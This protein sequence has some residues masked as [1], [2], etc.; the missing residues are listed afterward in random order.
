MQDVDGLPLVENELDVLARLVDLTDLRVLEV[1][2]GAARLARDLLEAHPG[3]TV[4]GIETDTV[5]LAKNQARPQSGLHFLQAS[6]TALPFANA[7]FDLVLM[8][9]S[10]HHIPMD[11]MDQ[12]LAEAARVL[13][14]GG[15][16][17]VSE[18]VYAGAFNAIV[19]LFNDEGVV[20]AAA[21]RALDRMLVDT[22]H[23]QAEDTVGFATAVT[24]TDFDTFERRMMRPTFADRHVDEALR[25]RVR[26]A[27]APHW[28]AGGA[29]FRRPMQVRLFRRRQAGSL[30]G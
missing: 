12:A 26:T 10:L 20:R 6:A 2:C 25:A 18:P 30:S 21:Q 3:C 5:Q 4:T 27:L 29:H 15:T 24:Y 23:W 1:G 16:L 19:R 9:K 14:P 17:Y 28:Q 7:V 22:A 11:G 8:L 13:K